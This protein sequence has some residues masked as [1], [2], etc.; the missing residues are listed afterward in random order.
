MQRELSGEI[1]TAESVSSG[2]ATFFKA[3]RKSWPIILACL[4]LAIGVSL[5]YTRTLPK[6]YRSTAMIEFDPNVVRPLDEKEDPMMMYATFWDNREYY[7]TQYKIITSDRVLSQVV[8]D[9]NQHSRGR[10]GECP[11]YFHAFGE[12]L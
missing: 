4:I 10:F 7:E 5:L 2:L 6:I 1:T 3:I 8:R 12:S 11:D 9:L